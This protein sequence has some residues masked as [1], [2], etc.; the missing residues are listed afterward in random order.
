MWPIFILTFVTLQRLAELMIARRNTAALL[1]KGGRE[2][3]AE[4]YFIIVLFHACWL[5]GL[6]ILAGD[7]AVNWFLIGLFAMLQALRVWV[8]STLG[9]RWTTRIILM[10]EKPLVIAG[11]FKFLRHPNYAVV[12]LE[13]FVLPFAFGL[14]WFGL[15]FGAIN[16]A[17]LAYRISVEERALSPQR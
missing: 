14:I 5:L 9:S 10:P 3:G 1:A 12:A 7:Q 15:I 17:I 16:L 8:L 4:H 6:W 11:P 13:I 2:V